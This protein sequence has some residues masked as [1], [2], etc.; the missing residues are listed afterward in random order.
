MSQMGA[1]SYGSVV[2][3]MARIQNAPMEAQDLTLLERGVF[4][5]FVFIVVLFFA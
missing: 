4:C 1:L 2:I 5:L 3:I